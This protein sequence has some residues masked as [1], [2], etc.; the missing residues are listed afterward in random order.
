MNERLSELCESLKDITFE[1]TENDELLFDI[2]E[3]LGDI[4]T[5][6]MN[7]GDALLQLASIYLG[8]VESR[9]AVPS[10]VRE[11]ISL[12]LAYSSEEEKVRDL[13]I[14]RVETVIAEVEDTKADYPDNAVELQ[15]TLTTLSD[16]ISHYESSI[17][18][19]EIWKSIEL[20]GQ[21]GLA[22]KLENIV[23]N[24]GI[25]KDK[26]EAI[27]EAISARNAENHREDLFGYQ[28]REDDGYQVYGPDLHIQ[29]NGALT[30]SFGITLTGE[31]GANLEDIEKM[32]PDL[33]S[34][35]QNMNQ[36]TDAQYEPHNVEY[37]NK[38]HISEKNVTEIEHG[39]RI[40]ALN[41]DQK[42][43]KTTEQALEKYASATC[44]IYGIEIL[45]RKE[46]DQVFREVKDSI[47][48]PV[49]REIPVDIS[50][51]KAPFEVR[52]ID[53]RTTTAERTAEES[54][55]NRSI[56]WEKTGNEKIDD[57]IEIRNQY[58]KAHPLSPVYRSNPRYAY[59]DMRAVMIARKEGVEI[60]GHVPTISDCLYAIGGF[61]NSN[62]LETAVFKILDVFFDHSDK[63]DKGVTTDLGKDV[64]IAVTGNQETIRD[65]LKAE[66]LENKKEAVD[67]LSHCIE[68]I[69]DNGNHREIKFGLRG[70]GFGK[71][72]GRII[73]VYGKEAPDIL[74]TTIIDTIR[75]VLE[76]TKYED[77]RF[78]VERAGQLGSVLNGY[79][80]VR[81]SEGNKINVDFK[82]ILKEIEAEIDKPEEQKKE[83]LELPEEEKEVTVDLEEEP[84]M[85][86]PEE[87][88]VMSEEE[89]SSEELI[90]DTESNPE[91]SIE[92]YYLD[93][94][95]QTEEEPYKDDPDDEKTLEERFAEL[96]GFEVEPQADIEENVRDS[97]VEG[98]EESE[99]F[100]NDVSETEVI[101]ENDEIEKGSE[102]KQTDLDE[103]ED[104]ENEKPSVQIEMD[105]DDR[106]QRIEI[107]IP[108]ED[109]EDGPI[110]VF[111]GDSPLVER[112]NEILDAAYTTRGFSIDVE[113]EI[114]ETISAA[115]DSIIEQAEKN[116]GKIETGVEFGISDIRITEDIGT[117]TLYPESYDL[118]GLKEISDEMKESIESAINPEEE[119]FVRE[120]TVS[121]KKED[122]YEEVTLT[123]EMVSSVAEEEPEKI[124]ISFIDTVD[125][126]Q[127]ILQDESDVPQSISQ[128][129]IPTE[130]TGYEQ[131]HTYEN[132]S[133]E[134]EKQEM[135]SPILKQNEE[136]ISEAIDAYISGESDYDSF[137]SETMIVTETGEVMSLY[138]ALQ[139]MVDVS[140]YVADKIADLLS[141]N[142]DIEHP[143]AY[144]E[145]LT[146]L[147]IGLSEEI[148]GPLLEKIDQALEERGNQQNET[149]DHI[150]EDLISNMPI[151]YPMEDRLDMAVLDVTDQ[152]CE[153]AVDSGIIDL[154]IEA[155]LTGDISLLDPVDQQ[156]SQPFEKGTDPLEHNETDMEIGFETNASEAV[157][158]AFQNDEPQNM[159]VTKDME[160]A[161]IELE[162]NLTDP[163]IMDPL[164]GEDI[165]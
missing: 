84:V 71:A 82:G 139:E 4:R 144:A 15:E 48:T 121:E 138:F 21:I 10:N 146:D 86:D 85:E 76:D 133:L 130:N 17:S 125:E 147:L 92:D 118:D 88:S 164:D 75:E 2:R 89:N 12:E 123:Q 41:P 72:A 53:R 16:E 162:E 143:E 124:E 35:I 44:K 154:G 7:D 126:A 117:D 46:I 127:G 156:E 26:Q 106:I 25:S 141:G 34:H 33:E 116:D 80:F 31:I 115:L 128:E 108:D 151:E 62:I 129:E 94:Y 93:D 113:K 5:I 14:E 20:Q 136:E 38:L 55:H 119:P 81:D 96:L 42:L 19:E 140:D 165:F 150:T 103:S 161:G 155:A 59:H 142:G 23:E 40:H 148:D 43:E 97:Q 99:S 122:S 63:V 111:D 91:D 149:W 131:E 112:L 101:M 56:I 8:S 24:F 64:R 32:F 110:L 36:I 13:L 6:L 11:A 109:G 70:S 145:R 51:Q 67:S 105:S 159:D 77:T 29:D 134:A 135:V 58:I 52:T 47:E 120:G 102:E 37:E 74:R 98:T 95:D 28:G 83:D 158:L 78:S 9:D 137:L 39:L 1:E 69:C 49:K 87:E 68:R 45:D 153:W 90:E 100:F 160:A 114:Y 152:L 61:W 132:T 73:E 3:T 104:D 66:E 157:D 65:A 50:R 107:T 163:L 22:V 57:H 30:D 54:L 18:H 27:K 60:N 79:R